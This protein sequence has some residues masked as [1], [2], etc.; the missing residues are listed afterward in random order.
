[1][2]RGTDRGLGIDFTFPLQEGF[3]NNRGETMIHEVGL[4]CTCNPEDLHAGQVKH[5]SHVLRRRSKFRCD[6]CGGEGYI[7]RKARKIVGLL[8][9]V[10]QTRSQLDAGWAVPGDALVSVK[11]EITISGGDLLTFTWPEVVPDGQ[12]IIRGAAQIS[13]NQTRVTHLEADEDRLLYNAV[14][15]IYCEDENGIVYNSGADFILDG[16]KII[17]WVG[18]KPSQKTVYTIKYTAYLEWVAF[19]PPDI[20]R[21]RDRDLGYRVAIRKR[22]VALA[23][24][25]PAGAPGDKTPFCDRLQGCTA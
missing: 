7:Y 24:D 16:S 19:F 6:I 20:R 18:S 12:V 11:P 3:I 15:S 10:R 1:M 23:N 14:A 2:S 17:K 21:D 13:D 4:R 9:S 5:G 8:T 25:D 22:H